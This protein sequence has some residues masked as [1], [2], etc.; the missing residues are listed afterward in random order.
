ML[1]AAADTLANP[2]EG[3]TLF[4]LEVEGL[5]FED[6]GRV[7]VDDMTFKLDGRRRTVIMGPNGAGKSLLLRLIHGLLV[8]KAGTIR[9][10]GQALDDM[11]RARQA[12]VFQRPTLLRRSASDNLR[13]VLSHLP[14]GERERRVEQLMAEARLE[15]VANSPARLLSG[16]EQQR[17]AIARARARFPEV[18]LLDEPSASLDPASTHAIEEMIRA[19]HAD[20]TKIVLVTHDVGQA[21]RLADDVLFVSR[22]RIAE[23]T[24]AAQFFTRPAAE[25]ARAYL[26][27]R[28]DL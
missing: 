6:R 23:Y 8:P 26:E 7:L 9:W 15:A 5:R 4:P 10:A 12:L 1:K 13:F 20:G 24:G 27:G 14:H 19:A 11:I 17:L 2:A 18:L 3:G 22:G 16:G 21:K 25:A 28:L